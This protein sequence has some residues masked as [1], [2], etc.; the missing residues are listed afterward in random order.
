VGDLVFLH[1]DTLGYRHWPL[2]RI[3]STYPGDNGIVEAVDVE[4]QGKNI[5]RRRRHRPSSRC[6]M[7]GKNLPL[8]G[9]S[10]YSYRHHGAYSSVLFSI[11]STGDWQQGS[12]PFPSPSMFRSISS[13]DWTRTRVQR[14]E[15]KTPHQ[16]QIPR[17][18]D[19]SLLIKN[20]QHLAYL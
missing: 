13:A 3:T 2:A 10:A 19:S 12:F 20:N 6:W 5:P 7:P 17:G 4:C 9:S 15:V 8:N 1:E 16:Q 18:Q 14:S 11:Y